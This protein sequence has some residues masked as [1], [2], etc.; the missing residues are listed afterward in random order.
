MVYPHCTF[1]VD[2][3]ADSQTDQGFSKAISI[4]WEEIDLA[5]TKIEVF[6]SHYRLCT[7]ART[8][9]VLDIF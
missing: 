6:L 5:E 3:T 4:I 2:S 1:M 7:L 8:Y 9:I